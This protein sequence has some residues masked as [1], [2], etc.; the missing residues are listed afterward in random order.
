MRIGCIVGAMVVLMSCGGPP[1]PVLA[2]GPMEPEAVDSAWNHALSLYRK[3]SWQEA[4]TAIEVT[5]AQFGPSDPRIAKA[6]FLVAE[7][8]LA[9]GEN[10]QAVRSFRRVSDDMPTDSLAPRALIRAGD[11]YAG[12]WRRPELDPTYGHTATAVYQEVLERYPGTEAARIAGVRMAE[13]NESFAI[14]EFKSARFYMRFKA[15][16][17]ALLTLRNLVADYPRTKMAPVALLEMIK[18]FRVLGYEEDLRETC[19][20]LARQHPDTPET[21]KACT[22]GA[23]TH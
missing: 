19:D 1:E 23:T 4:R 5:V 21:D 12:L 7:T 18:A 22:G 11:A 14:K 10:L 3:G 13:L 17:S 2:P 15:Y 16:D 8:Q 6:R 20:Y 9:R